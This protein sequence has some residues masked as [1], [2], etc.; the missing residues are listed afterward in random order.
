MKIPNTRKANAGLNCGQKHVKKLALNRHGRVY[1][2]K[3]HLRL[4]VCGFPFDTVSVTS[5]TAMAKNLHMQ[6]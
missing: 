2:F 4:N 3:P 1:W 5:I 6:Q